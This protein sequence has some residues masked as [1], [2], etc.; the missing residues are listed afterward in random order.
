MMQGVAVPRNGHP[1][2]VLLRLLACEFS[3]RSAAADA[4]VYFT[5]SSGL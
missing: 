5:P 2:D 3:L 1:S 4:K